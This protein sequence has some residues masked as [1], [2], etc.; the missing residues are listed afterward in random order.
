M[1][2]I[3]GVIRLHGPEVLEET[4][5][6]MAHSIEHRGPDA[7]G[8]RIDE[9]GAMAN[10][11]LSI[12]DVEHGQQPAANEDQSVHV[13]FNGEIYNHTDLRRELEAERHQLAS[14]SD[15]EVLPHLYE[16]HGEQMLARL[17]GMFAFALQDTRSHRWLLARDRLGIKPLFYAHVDDR[18]YFGSEIKAILAASD[19][20][21][22]VDEEA[23]ELYLSLRYL[24]APWTMF[25]GIRRLPPGKA[26]IVEADGQIQEWAYWEPWRSP[27][28]GDDVSVDVAADQIRELLSD[29]VRLRLMS[30]VPFGAFLSGGLDSSG[31]VALMAQHMDEPVQTFSIGFSEESRVDETTHARTVAD[32]CGTRHREVDCTAERVDL[33]PKLL[34]H[35]DEPFADPI[36][37]PTH[38]VSELAREHVK[39]VLTGEGADELFG[40]YTRYVRDRS[41]QRMRIL[42]APLR[43]ALA[44]AGRHA[45]PGH[46]LTRAMAMSTQSAPGRALSWVSAFEDDEL[47]T[48]TS[49]SPTGAARRLYE[50]IAAESPA[51]N[52]LETLMF[53][54][55]RLRL[56]DCMLARTD[57]M[58]MAVSLEGRTP[59]LD[60]R[61][62]EYVMW[63]PHRLKVN[64]GEEKVA[65]K[66]AL[67][68][69]LPDSTTQR[70]KQGLAVPFAQWARYG[71]ETSIRRVLAPKAVEARGLLQPHAVAGLLDHWGAHASRQSQQVWSLMCLELWFRL[72]VDNE[73]LPAD[74]PL[75]QVG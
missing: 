20:H 17:N 31:V 61:L 64:R 26:L 39:V 71:V 28:S 43:L 11:R 14:H 60:H 18:I 62:V 72:N 16:E 36:I 23:V 40:G 67:A 48:V 33:L 54:E 24:P 52:D 57:R 9:G 63:L 51:G 15:T 42:P 8:L 29:S 30:D 37:V 41:I 6:C 32:H 45:A 46:S 66:R 13:V 44:A 12:I 55:Q 2:G 19:V 47:A 35:F 53:C 50:Q 1:C 56:P 73:R 7:I 10:C 21:F 65:L 68:P 25:K 58:T 59:F 49:M 22:E 4:I 34:H 38:Q 3:A 27:R 69:L 74:T 70:R 5:T 75:S